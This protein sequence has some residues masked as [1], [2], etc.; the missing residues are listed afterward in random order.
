MTVSEMIVQGLKYM[1]IGVS[2]VFVVLAVF[3]VVI[4]LLMKI[5]PPKENS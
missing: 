5:W 1:G 3:F 4:K 2:V